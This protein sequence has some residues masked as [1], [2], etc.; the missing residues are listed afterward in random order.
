MVKVAY[1]NCMSMWSTTHVYKGILARLFEKKQF[2][3][4]E[5]KVQHIDILN[6]SL[7]EGK[8]SG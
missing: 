7:A 6:K 1:L 3:R 4:R 5:K 2:D 8:G